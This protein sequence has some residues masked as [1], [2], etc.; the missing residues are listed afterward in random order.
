[1]PALNFK[2]TVG[3]KVMISSYGLHYE[4]LVTKCIYTGCFKMIYDVEFCQN[5]EIKDRWFYEDQLEPFKHHEGR[6]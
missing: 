2:Y 4:G 6:E 1:M 5:G 3:D